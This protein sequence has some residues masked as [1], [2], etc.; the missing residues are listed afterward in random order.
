MCFNG[1]GNYKKIKININ[2]Q[3]LCV[4]IVKYY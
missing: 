1:Y 2:N 4:L 3:K